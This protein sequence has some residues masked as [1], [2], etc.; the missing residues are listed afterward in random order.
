MRP[1]TEEM[2]N[3]RRGTMV[4]RKKEEEWNENFICWNREQRY[5]ELSGKEQLKIPWEKLLESW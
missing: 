1:E 3:P 4:V 2:D 5:P